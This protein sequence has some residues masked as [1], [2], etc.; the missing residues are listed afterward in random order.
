MPW[1]QRPNFNSSLERNYYNKPLEY[2]FV[3][4]H[5]P[6]VMCR[7]LYQNKSR[8]MRNTLLTNHNGLNAFQSVKYL[9][10]ANAQKIILDS[11]EYYYGCGVMYSLRVALNHNRSDHSSRQNLYI[12][13]ISS[14]RKSCSLSID[15]QRCRNNHISTSSLILVLWPRLSTEIRGTRCHSQIFNLGADWFIALN[16]AV[17]GL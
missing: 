3:R 1:W 5:L 2:C 15:G 14:F 11:R 9:V 4:K 7:I 8:G 17:I 16:E 12:G 10:N 6:R 13:G